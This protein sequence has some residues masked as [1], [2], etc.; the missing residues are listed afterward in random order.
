MTDPPRPAA[1]G[2]ERPATTVTALDTYDIRFPD[3]DFRAAGRKENR[4]R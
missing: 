2:R 3:G 4:H 1:S